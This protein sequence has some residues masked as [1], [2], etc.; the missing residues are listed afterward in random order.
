MID[1]AIW[2]YS[3]EREKIDSRPISAWFCADVSVAE[4]TLEKVRESG[5]SAE[6]VTA[7]TPIKERMKLLAQH[8]EGEV[9]AML[10]VGV[11]AEGWDNP[12]CNII[13]HLRPT[14]S[15]VL[16]GQSVG[17]GL[18]SAAGKEKCVV[19]DVSSNW[20]TFGPVEKLQWSL[21]SHRRS[22]MEFMNRFNWIGKQQDGEDSDTVYLLCKLSLIHI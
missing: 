1:Y 20:S 16:W 2:A 10:S 5:I 3:E 17:R 7:T 18:R 13:V 14:L 15:K 22:F 8:E 11:L 6:I 21:W 12:H 9:E 19:I 4:A